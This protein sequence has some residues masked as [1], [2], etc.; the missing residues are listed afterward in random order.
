M[1]LFY[2]PVNPSKIL[3]AATSGVSSHFMFNLELAKTLLARGH[4]V[5]IIVDEE[6]YEF[7]V[8]SYGL[9]PEIRF[10][11]FKNQIT[12]CEAD[13]LVKRYVSRQLRI[14]EA[15]S[16]L[17]YRFEAEERELRAQMG[18]G[19]KPDIFKLSSYV[20][21]DM[22]SNTEAMA[23]LKS[24]GFD[25]VVGDSVPLYQVILSQIL[26]VPY[27]Q[28][29]LTPIAPSQHDRFADNP[30]NPAYVPERMS[31]LSDNMT[32][33]E[34]VKNTILYWVTGFFYYKYFLGPMDGVLRKHNIRPDANFGQLLKEADMWIFN[35]DFVVD[36]ARP[37]NPHVKFVGGVLTSPAKPLDEVRKLSEKVTY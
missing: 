4:E 22:L 25:M 37:L 12:L 31:F 30:S 27:I 11:F 13:I 17:Q 5:W 28:L 21:D 3:V 18:G 32:F 1:L 19:R 35:S 24:V 33:R 6:T 20:I 14:A 2:K 7:K 34:R 16:A 23:K 9:P 10:V 36:F 15:N 29:G 26:K 8:R